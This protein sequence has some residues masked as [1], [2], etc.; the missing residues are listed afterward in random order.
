MKEETKKQQELKEQKKLS[1]DELLNVTGGMS[2]GAG[3]VNKTCSNL[4]EAECN[5]LDYCRWETKFGYSSC[6]TSSIKGELI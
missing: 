6:Q 2:T 3:G 5:K 1:N 4:S